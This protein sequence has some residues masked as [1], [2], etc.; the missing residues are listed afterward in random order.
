MA[1]E[2]AVVLKF[3]V[4]AIFYP[5]GHGLGR[6]QSG[7]CKASHSFYLSSVCMH[8]FGVV[9]Y[10]HIYVSVTMLIKDKYFAS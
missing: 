5:A 7:T 1:L 6:N 3:M 10:K 8:I 2:E 4:A 9:I